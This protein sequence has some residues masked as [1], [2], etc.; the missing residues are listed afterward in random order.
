[1]TKNFLYLIS[2]YVRTYGHK[3]T[4]VMKGKTEAFF[5]NLG[6]W[7]IAGSFLFVPS[8][9]SADI[10]L[11]HYF[12]DHMVIQRDQPITVWGW[13]DAGEKIAVI[14]HDEYH[15]VVADQNGK[16]NCVLSAQSASGPLEMVVKGK[17][18]VQINDILIGDVWVAS[19]Q[20][21]M[22]W[23]LKQ[24]PYVETD[25]VWMRSAL[26]R[27]FTVQVA[28]DYMPREDVEGGSWQ[29]M[30]PDHI[31]NFSAVAYHFA[32]F[33]QQ[34]QKIPVGIIN[35]SL[36]ATSIETWMSN[37]SL[38][39]FDQFR[40]E[41]LPI[42]KRGK[43]FAEIKS[44]FD[45]HKPKW[46]TEEYLTGAG[47]EEKW[48][49][50]E[51]DISKW[52][53]IQVPGFWEDQG[54]QGHD[55]AVWYRKEFDMPANVEGHDSLLLQ[56]S[57]IDDYDITW[58]NG[59]KL[60]ET[61]GRHNH[62][63]Y[64][65]PKALL[66]E[67]RNVLVVRAFDIGDKGGFSTNAF[68]MS[69]MI[70]GTWKARRGLEIDVGDFET[71]P[72]VNV[73]PFSSP[74]VL[75]NANIAPL[76]KMAVKGIIWYQGES[77]A[78]RAEEYRDLFSTMIKDWRTHWQD[79]VLPFLFVQLANY[80]AENKLPASS[81]WAELREAQTLALELPNTG[82]AVAIDIGE[83]GDIH[84][85]NKVDVGKRLALAANSIAYKKSNIWHGP[86][87]QNVDFLDGH[88]LVSYDPEGG[89]ILTKDKFGYIRG[90]ELAGADQKFHWAQAKIEGNQIRVFCDQV[91]NPVALRYCWSDNPGTIDLYNK[92]GHPALPF[93]TDHWPGITTG[94]RFDHQQARF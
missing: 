71:L 43:S 9:L 85:K 88:A 2:T 15:N 80:K 39:G 56:L 12:G 51:T 21:N 22:Q 49:L 54:M 93:R 7:L 36:G 63:N 19:G 76:T 42:I 84:P 14:F 62:R 79:P 23:P 82:M 1:V 28:S 69:E 41:I 35:C 4:A 3:E 40:P 64:W 75:F 18:T 38:A 55:G 5:A 78:E 33:V 50:P 92:E 53:D 16:W 86:K 59:V 46:E 58:V 13:A 72:S 10:R 70:R 30:E 24:T 20:S 26:L 48:Y 67:K 44:E 94:K 11:P 61:Y 52:Q 68:W 57:Q 17:N 87:V 29:V 89:S 90:F 37:E 65:M 60:G 47:M 32:R 73:T 77:N 8:A 25:T 27:L 74:G 45:L 83:A 34:D 31:A 6:T 81:D 91:K 66:K